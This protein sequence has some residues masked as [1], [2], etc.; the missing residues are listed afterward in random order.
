[1]M[2]EYSSELWTLPSLINKSGIW[3][4]QDQDFIAYNDQDL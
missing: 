1:M 4:E 3:Y 2:A